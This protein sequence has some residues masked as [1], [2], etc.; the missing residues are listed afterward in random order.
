MSQSRA[1]RRRASKGGH[2]PKGPRRD[3]MVYVYAGFALLVVLIFAVFALWKWQ[4]NR[5]VIE[6]FATPTPGPSSTLKPIVLVNGG[7]LGKGFFPFGDTR[8]GGQGSPV[9][10]IT[11]DTMEGAVYHVHSHLALFIS[12]KQVAIPQYIGIVPSAVGTPCLYWLHTHDAAG[13]I[14]VESPEVGSPNGGPF[15]LGMFFDIWGQPLDATHI[16]LFQGPVTAYVNGAKYDG[17]LRAIPLG[18]HQLITLE[19]GSPVT[20]PN[21]TFPAGE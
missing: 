1:E 16:G 11:C 17:D 5:R 9:D 18:A 4:E 2:G 14:H 12:G 15:T 8:M 20:P 19:I 10:G 3:P 6:A 21:Y 7:H 13:I